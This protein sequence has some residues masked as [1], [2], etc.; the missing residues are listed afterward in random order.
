M[1]RLLLFDGCGAAS[2]G[3]LIPPLAVHSAPF[4]P[5]PKT[6]EAAELLA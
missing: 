2:A 4:Y 5:A 6:K 1:S 3:N